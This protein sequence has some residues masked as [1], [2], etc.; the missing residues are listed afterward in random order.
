[1]GKLGSVSAVGAKV[2]T[3]LDK[4]GLPRSAEVYTA[5]AASVFALGASA[6]LATGCGVAHAD[7]GRNT[8]NS[9]SSGDSGS[10][11]SGASSS[12]ASARAVSSSTTQAASSLPKAVRRSLAQALPAAPRQSSIA[13]VPVAV[14]SP[15]APQQASAAAASTGSSPAV[16]AIGLVAAVGS[17]APAA[18]AAPAAASATK[19]TA[20]TATFSR[21]TGG[22]GKPKTSSASSTDSTASL[23]ALFDNLKPGQTLTLNANTTYSHSGVLTISVPNVTI[24]GNG[25]TLQA[26]NDITSALSITGNGVTLTNLNLSAPLTGTRYSD[27]NQNSLNIEG[28]NVTVSNV[29]ITGSAA[30]GVFVYGASGFN[31]SN[32]TVQNTRADGVHIT[33]GSS[34]GQLTNVTTK[35]TGDDGIAIV[36]YGADPSPSHDIVINSS[37][38]AGTTWGRGLS[39]V[40]GYN[41]TVNNIKVSSSSAAGIYIADEGAPWYTRSVNNVTIN[42]GT[43]TGANTSTTVIHGAVLIYSGNAGAGISGV[44]IN[45]LT[46]ASTTSTAGRNLGIIVDAGSVSGINLL[47]IALKNTNLYPLGLYNV[48]AGSYTATGWT[49]NGLPI[50]VV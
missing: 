29:T 4:Q 8:S 6:L 47:N 25:A 45:G 34:F 1:M 26:T 16:L 13:T 28:N 22:F 46:V 44:T 10:A 49:L 19:V 37:T 30:A 21:S 18:G 20:T 3:N 24:N 48:P 43:V 14:S 2:R 27:L 41:V 33:N 11:K 36:S 7:T 17:A 40:G 50:K 5:L 32:V 9:T 38:V 23:Q 31:L 42:G 39:V 35:M 12:A 15:P